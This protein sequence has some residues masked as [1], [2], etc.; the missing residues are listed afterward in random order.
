MEKS[1]GRKLV[2]RLLHWIDD[3]TSRASTAGLVILVVICFMVV[4]AAREFPSAWEN[5]FSMVASAITLVMVFVIQH[6]QSR[7]QVATQLKLD[8][9]IRA[10]PRADDLLI[11]VES[12]NDEELIAMDQD[13]F[14]QHS[15]IREA[16]SEGDRPDGG[17]C[18]GTVVT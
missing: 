1:A 8:E 12:A 14:D 10:A 15:A 5:A 6:T 17:S 9:L 18:P 7:Q 4:L 13:G 11:H 3:R 16:T 2:S